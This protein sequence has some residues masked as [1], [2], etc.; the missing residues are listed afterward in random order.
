MGIILSAVLL[1]VRAGTSNFKD[2]FIVRRLTGT[3]ILNLF[4]SIFRLKIHIQ[5][6]GRGRLSE[7]SWSSRSSDLT[8]SLNR[9]A[10]E[11]G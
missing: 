10:R 11:R 2:S 8:S 3:L 7:I 6:A 5:E 4:T 9:R 1:V